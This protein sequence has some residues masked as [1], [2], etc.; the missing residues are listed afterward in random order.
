MKMQKYQ[1]Q[2]SKNTAHDGT[3]FRYKHATLKNTAHD[4]ALKS[5][6]CM[7]PQKHHHPPGKEPCAKDDAKE[8]ANDSASK[9]QRDAAA[10]RSPH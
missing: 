4:N 8:H 3:K 7:H 10:A 5:M 1:K 2:L 9:N 6:V